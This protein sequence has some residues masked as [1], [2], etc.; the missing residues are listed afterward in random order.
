MKKTEGCLK[1]WDQHFEL[2]FSF[3]LVS[4]FRSEYFLSLKYYVSKMLTIIIS[5]WSYWKNS[6]QFSFFSCFF[7]NWIF[8]NSNILLNQTKPELSW[9][10]N[11]E[12]N[13][14]KLNQTNFLFFPHS[15]LHSFKSSKP[16]FKDFVVCNCICA[17]NK[18]VSLKVIFYFILFHFTF[19]Q[20]KLI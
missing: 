1:R 13:S 16:I 7:Q 9:N 6:Q 17:R 14:T 10:Q 15:F 4:V 11:I 18:S 2:Q 5:W 19:S 12:Q 3:S 20:E 8:Q